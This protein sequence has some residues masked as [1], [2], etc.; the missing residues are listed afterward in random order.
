M[1]SSLFFAPLSRFAF[2]F[3][4][5][6]WL[7]RPFFIH[8][9]LMSVPDFHFSS[10]LFFSEPNNNQHHIA[11]HLKSLPAVTL[12]S[13]DLKS[14]III[15]VFSRLSVL[16]LIVAVTSNHEIKFHACTDPAPMS[17]QHDISTSTGNHLT[18]YSCACSCTCGS[19]V[20]LF[21]ELFFYH[22]PHCCFYHN[23]IN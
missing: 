11:C 3:S 10:C 16:Y 14:S 21:S 17:L 20:P 23:N 5:F 15:V 6:L 12:P 8:H 7:G 2:A 4:S 18:S 19:V 13:V 9:R 22:H 1:Q